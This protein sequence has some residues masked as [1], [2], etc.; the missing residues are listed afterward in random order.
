MT[1]VELTIEQLLED[2]NWAQVFADENDGNVSKETSPALPDMKIDLTPP[3]RTDVAQII[4]AVNGENDE[5]DWLG[6]F[7]LKDG[8]YLVASGGCDYTGWDCQAG[9]SLVVAPTLQD[10]IRFGLG[11]SERARLGF[12]LQQEAN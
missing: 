1:K 4:A 3:N 8:R 10:A 12:E 9:N 11:E 6:L 5:D 7:L 2:G